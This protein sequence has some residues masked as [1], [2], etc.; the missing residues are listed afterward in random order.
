MEWFKTLHGKKIAIITGGTAGHVI[1]ANEL[2]AYCDAD[3]FVNDDGVKF[4]FYEKRQVFS[5]Q[6]KD[7]IDSIFFLFYFIL[8]CFF[9]TYVLFFLNYHHISL[10]ASSTH[11]RNSVLAL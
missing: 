7:L 3:L 1:P 11:V 2:A 4:C 6:E 10:H 9:Y 8:F 5:F